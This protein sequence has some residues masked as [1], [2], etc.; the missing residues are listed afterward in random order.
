MAGSA[1]RRRMA[2]CC[3]RGRRRSAPARTALFMARR[4]PTHHRA[5]SWTRLWMAALCRQPRRRRWM[6]L[7]Q[8]RSRPLAFRSLR[9]QLAEPTGRSQRRRH[10]QTR[11]HSDRVLLR[12]QGDALAH[13][14]GALC[15][16]GGGL[17]V[18]PTQPEPQLQHQPVTP[19]KW[20]GEQILSGESGKAAF[21]PPYGCRILRLRLRQ[22][23]NATLHRC[24]QRRLSHRLRW[25]M[26]EKT[27]HDCRQVTASP[28]P[29]VL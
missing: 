17:Q 5:R 20:R 7:H 25:R 9:S 22:S 15:G 4:P 3:S 11:A 28:F 23:F 10:A 21:Q 13:A 12:L 1:V 29:L 14:D 24:P 6:Q 27:G 8:R 18:A 16:G 19:T 2:R 26:F